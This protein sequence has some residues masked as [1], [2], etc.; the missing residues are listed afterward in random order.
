ME[1]LCVTETMDSTKRHHP[2]SQTEDA[3]KRHD[4]NLTT[5][6]RTKLKEEFKMKTR[7]KLEERFHILPEAQRFVTY[8]KTTGEI[9]Y[10]QPMSLAI[11]SCY[12]KEQ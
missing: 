11:P 12:I 10:C 5:T 3:L 2:N 4:A 7:C 9:T 6:E 8:L 1:P